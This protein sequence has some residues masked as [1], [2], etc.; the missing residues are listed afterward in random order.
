METLP[1]VTRPEEFNRVLVCLAEV[2]AELSEVALIDIL[3][4]ATY[5][6]LLPDHSGTLTAA[7]HAGFVV[8]VS[9]R[10]SLT[11]LGRQFLAL[12]PD[13]VYELTPG[14]SGFLY[15]NLI[16]RP[17]YAAATRSFFSLFRSRGKELGFSLVLNNLSLSK[18]QIGLMSILRRLGVIKIANGVALVTKEYQTQISVI[19]SRHII[20]ADELEAMLLQRKLSGAAAEMLVLDMERNR[21]RAAGFPIEATAVRLISD[22]DVAAG[23]DIESF[24][25]GSEALVPDRFIEV[26]STSTGEGR[27]FWSRNEFATAQDLQSKYWIYHLRRFSPE[28]PQGSTCV[29]LNDPISMGHSGAIELTCSQYEAKFNI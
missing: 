18:D 4:S 25:G 14:Q 27:F 8:S 12:N 22:V 19:R 28:N 20:T 13:N 5:Q 16:Q 21:L 6:G 23:Y 10:I 7:L 24:D 1:N 29:I 9:G 15:Q 17:P 11:S 3:Q 26:K 2:D